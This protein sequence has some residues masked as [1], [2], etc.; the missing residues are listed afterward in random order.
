MREGGVFRSTTIRLVAAVLAVSMLASCTSDPAE[1]NDPRPDLVAELIPGVP[2]PLSAACGIGICVSE[3][4]LLPQGQ[5]IESA[6]DL[7]QPE[8]LQLLAIERI[9]LGPD[10]EGLF[11]TG[12]L[13]MLDTKILDGVLTGPLP[14]MPIGPV[15]VDASVM[16][17]DGTLLRFDS[18]G[19]LVEVC[20]VQGLCVEIE[21]RDDDVLLTA[22]DA[23]RW[24][25]VELVDGT[26]KRAVTSDGREVNYE[27]PEGVLA[28]V[29]NE[30]G[31]TTYSYD[32]GLLTSVVEPDGTRRIG[33]ADGRVSQVTDRDGD[34]WSFS[35]SSASGDQV[36]MR[37]TSGTVRDFTFSD[38]RLQRVVDGTGEV[39]LDRD[40]DESGRLLE[41][42]L[43]MEGIR[44]TRRSDGSVEVRDAPAEGGPARVIVYRYDNVGRVTSAEGPDGNFTYLYDGAT[45][46]LS[47]LRTESGAATRYGYDANGLLSTVTD[48]DGYTI[49]VTRYEDG[50]PA[51]VNDR[52][53]EQTFD[54]DTR[55]RTVEQRTGDLVTTY[56][57]DQLGRP[58]AER[59]GF[60]RRDFRYD[61]AGRLTSLVD[62]DLRQVLTYDEFG[63]LVESDSSAGDQ[64]S[65][66]WDGSRTVGSS[67]NGITADEGTAPAVSLITSGADAGDYADAAG[68][69]YSFDSA[70]RAL[71]VTTST[72]TTRRS[73]DDTGRLSSIT[74]PDGRSYSITRS[75][76][77]RPTKVTDWAG[78]EIDLVWDGPRLISVTTPAGTTIDYSWN[79]TGLL[80]SIQA[81]PLRW[82]YTYDRHGY[83]S[84]VTTP[85]GVVHHDWDVA[86]QPT[87]TA[88]PDGSETTYDWDGDA[89]ARVVADG[90]A[91]LELEWDELDR[92]VSVATP[93]G[94]DSYAY[95]DTGDELVGYQIEGSDRVDIGYVNRQI[96]TLTTG[97]RTEAWAWDAGEVTE[98]RTGDDPDDL[99]EL[100]W[101]S[102][103][104]LAAIE[105]EQSTIV[106]VERDI[107][108]R[109]TSINAG[110]DEVARYRWDTNRYLTDA[111]I[112]DETLSLSTNADGQIIEYVSDDSTYT[113]EY[114]GGAPTRIG[115][116][117][118]TLQFQYD[119]GALSGS[120]FTRNDETVTLGWEQGQRITTMSS[121]E[122]TGGFVY[123]EDGRITSI[124]YDDRDREVTY[125]SDGSASAEGT[126]GELL[127][128]LFTD[129]GLP[130][131]LPA[132]PTEGPNIPILAS[133]PAELGIMMPDVFSPFDA[134]DATLAAN[135]PT[136]PRPLIPSDDPMA[137]ARG[138]ADITLTGAATYSLPTGPVTDTRVTLT[139]TTDA[140]DE[141][142]D[143]TPTSV[144]ARVTLARLAPDPCL[145]C[146]VVDA[147][148][149]A[150]AGIANGFTSLWRFVADNAIVQA[151]IGIAFFA[152]QMYLCQGSALCTGS[153]GAANTA[154]FLFANAEF[155]SIAGLLES[156]VLAVAQPFVNLIRDPSLATLTTAAINVAALLPV[157][158]AVMPDRAVAHATSR[159]SMNS[160][161]V[162]PRASRAVDDLSCTL[163][164]VV[165]IS[166]SRY[167]E[168]ADHYSDAIAAGQPRLLTTGYSGAVRRRHDSLSG[169]PTKLGFDRDEY[170]FAMTLQGG[171]G[172][173]V[174]YLDPS[175][176]RAVGSY[177]RNQLPDRDGY[178]FMVRI[179]D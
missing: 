41:E 97:S 121:D 151:A 111:V 25:E 62:N 4:V 39:L 82:G 16:L 28:S 101:N 77:G 178:R 10:H 107:A 23:R 115:D 163:Q 112:D 78:R 105:R 110:D 56:S 84:E 18:D 94:T 65:V 104:Q 32:N 155:D 81:G 47:E 129:Q 98:V 35:W 51:T 179:V 106:T 103:G 125:D 124:R 90:T 69:V 147:G 174:R 54:Y 100:T 95:D 58:L 156:A 167:G 42:A 135:L 83:L 45:A 7:E 46:R 170:P 126:G 74:F 92:I 70:G 50:L 120:T 27:I 169:I 80:D 159:L 6:A 131:T 154:L 165:C 5:F 152:A 73:F 52:V 162:A 127:G 150:I 71:T 149:A 175:L 117:D 63:R 158:G 34:V 14:A 9:F 36:R 64:V 37:R 143:A 164:R 22:A 91:L 119:D 141:L 109:V 145:L 57:Y 72:G 176:N 21:W 75:S 87:R 11:G 157:V 76:G 153:L 12:W 93:N 89:L 66:K 67:L 79:T 88:G 61:T 53:V 20:P 24:V 2:G 60:H 128:D 31:T 166:R 13:S 17:A 59:T 43:P 116:G 30:A 130:A 133:L 161:A 122:G 86:G 134:V 96:A 148:S 144:A 55:G 177:V 173:S 123:A 44:T 138:L 15:A 40:F 160:R 146:R 33:Y 38:G 118:T 139:P 114:N 132:A 171:S 1:S 19:S 136:V 29:V 85:N 113:A 8:P 142:L 99:Y 26:A 172:A 68:N 48:P 3:Q 108:Q 168:L 137:L 49:S 140:I 102:P